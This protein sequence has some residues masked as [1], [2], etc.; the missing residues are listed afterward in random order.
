MD[1]D[2]SL[3]DVLEADLP[4]FFAHQ[5]D[6]EAQAMAAFTPRDP[7]D[8]EAFMARW[9]RI[10]ADPTKISRTIAVDGQVAGSISSY[11]DEGRTEVT[12]W[13]GRDYWGKG[14]ATRALAEF[15]E[16]A[17]PTRPIHARVAKDNVGSLRVLEKCG[18]RIVGEDRGFANARGRE[19]EEFLLQ[20][21]GGFA[22]P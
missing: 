9:R 6:P 19:V 4:V 13:L 5:L 10:L 3:R 16:R 17:D 1:G 8:R 20:L 14:L 11:Q 22:F 15:L 21:G 12:Y 18:F 7:A 2:L